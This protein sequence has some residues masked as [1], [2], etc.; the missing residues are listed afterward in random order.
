[1]KFYD[2][3]RKWWHSNIWSPQIRAKENPYGSCFS[4]CTCWM[5]QNIDP[6][7]FRDYLTPDNVTE[8]INGEQWVEWT[9]KNIGKNVA[10][11]YYNRLNELWQVNEAFINH[12]LAESGN[13]ARVKFSIG[14]D[15]YNV[16]NH[17]KKGPVI[18][19]TAPRYNGRTLGH[20]MLIVG[21]D[22]A[23]N[24][25]IDDPF[26]DFRDGYKYGHLDGG[27]DIHATIEEF[28]NILTNYRIYVL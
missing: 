7:A 11:K 3:I 14:T 20:V 1:M 8:M 26:G 17:L 13:D 18:V 21:Y 22:E 2:K 4:H 16:K 28:K 27:N 9:V 6:V 5:L 25:I 19:S 12:L 24:F 23:D 10:K 15:I